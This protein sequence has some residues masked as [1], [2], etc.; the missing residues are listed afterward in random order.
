ME[1]KVANMLSKNKISEIRKLHLK[2]FR[3]KECLFIAEGEKVVKELLWAKYPVH[4][5]YATEKWIA[6]TSTILPREVHRVTDKEM[7]RLTCF[8]DPSPVLAIVK[9]M[10]TTTPDTNFSEFHPLLLLDGIRDPGNMG[11]IIRIADW[12]GF[13]QILCSPDSVEYTNPKVIQASMGS[14][15]RVQIGYTLL[16]DFLKQQ[17][18]KRQIYGAF[19]TGT[20]IEKVDFSPYDILIIGSETRGISPELLPFIHQ[21]ITIPAG[22]SGQTESL[23]AAI[24]TAIILYEWN[25]KYVY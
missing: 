8:K 22:K 3:T 1:C 24:A 4:E 2:K 17:S 13:K 23:N 15:C 5:I 14:F 19:L 11:T 12:F 21:K 18:D 7:E 16:P 6:P 20:A 10:D 25:R 9:Q